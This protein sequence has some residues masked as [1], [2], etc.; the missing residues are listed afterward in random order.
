[1]VPA[2]LRAVGVGPLACSWS[3]RGTLRRPH[4]TS[5]QV[6]VKCAGHRRIRA[7]RDVLFT[8][9]AS[10]PRLLV[11]EADRSCKRDIPVPLRSQPVVP[12]PKLIDSFTRSVADVMSAPSIASGQTARTHL[13][14]LFGT[15]C[16]K[17]THL[18][19]GISLC[20]G[21][22]CRWRQA[23]CAVR[24]LC[25]HYGGRFSGRFRRFAS[26]RPFRAS[27]FGNRP[28]ESA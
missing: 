14:N 16:L 1:M 15:P 26:I 28:A 12:P 17:A 3:R 21:C 7:R 25:D 5:K 2:S 6:T 23:Q 13:R 24:T 18:S 20:R 10:A 11:R 8:G 4:H 27:Q 19:H 9:A 22:T